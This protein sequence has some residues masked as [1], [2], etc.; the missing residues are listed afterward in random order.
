MQ[1]QLT[2]RPGSTA[3]FRRLHLIHVLPDLPYRA[4]Q[5]MSAG[6]Q[7]AEDCTRI[8]WEPIDQ[9]T[10]LHLYPAVGGA[11]QSLA[12]TCIQLAPVLLSPI[13]DQSFRWR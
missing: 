13:T 10:R 6:E 8:V 5:A 3:P 9:A 2:T 7:D 4:R 11:I 12:G 1:D